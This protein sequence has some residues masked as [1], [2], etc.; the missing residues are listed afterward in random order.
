MFN[1]EVAHEMTRVRLNLEKNSVVRQV[2]HEI[3][4]HLF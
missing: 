3:Q 4:H 2:R 1:L